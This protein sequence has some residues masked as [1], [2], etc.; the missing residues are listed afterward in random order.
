M[1]GRFRFRFRRAPISQWCECRGFVLLRYY[2]RRFSWLRISPIV[3]G[4]LHMF[5]LAGALRLWLERDGRLFAPQPAVCSG[6]PKQS[7]VSLLLMDRAALVKCVSL[8]PAF[9]TAGTEAII[10]SQRFHFAEDIPGFTWFHIVRLPFCMLDLLLFLFF[11]FCM[12]Q[13]RLYLNPRLHYV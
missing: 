1:E 13:Y 5:Y 7:H 6:S 12:M 3:V 9:S 10:T 11:F 8:C 4:A 2:K